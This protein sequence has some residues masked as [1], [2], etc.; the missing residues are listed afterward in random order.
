MSKEYGL[1]VIFKSH[2]SIVKYFRKVKYSNRVYH[3]IK[4]LQKASSNRSDVIMTFLQISSLM[5]YGS[6]IQCQKIYILCFVST[7]CISFVTEYIVSK[8]VHCSDVDLIQCQK[9]YILC[10]V[11]TKYICVVTEHIIS[12]AV[13]CSD[14]V[15]HC[16]T[17]YVA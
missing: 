8:A 9:I 14:V 16:F 2:R 17:V 6:M 5:S 4:P 11:S 3:E 15:Q 1:L 12:M 10:F 7:K 13:Q